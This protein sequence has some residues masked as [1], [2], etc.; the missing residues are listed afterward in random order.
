MSTS[1]A[2]AVVPPGEVTFWR[3]VAGGSSL[4]NR[5]SPAPVTVARARRS[6]DPRQARRDARL[7]QALDEVEHVGR[8]RARHGRDGVDE[9]LRGSHSTM[10]LLPEQRIGH[11]R[12][13]SLTSG[14]A[15]APWRR[16]R[17]WRAGSAWRARRRRPGSR[18]RR[19]PMVLP[20]RIEIDEGASGPQAAR[21]RGRRVVQ[22]L[23]LDGEHQHLGGGRARGVQGDAP[24]P[25]EP[26]IS[27]DGCGSR[28]VTPRAS[29]RP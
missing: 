14:L 21:S 23:R 18:E 6:R 5:S 22:H 9:V 27:S 29:A 8:A 11:G 1:S 16:G 2:A 25:A 4:W 3:S 7:G 15:A 19:S 24:L 28:T 17:C 20:A 26:V 10:P 13:A 12:C